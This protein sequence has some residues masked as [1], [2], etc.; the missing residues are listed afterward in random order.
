MVGTFL[1][2]KWNVKFCRRALSMATVRVEADLPFP[3]RVN[4][5]PYEV[6]TEG[7]IIAIS[8]TFVPAGFSN[9]YH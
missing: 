4:P 9:A 3:L 2:R 7:V 1:D 5:T 8:A 6:E